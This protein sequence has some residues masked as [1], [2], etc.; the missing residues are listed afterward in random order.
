MEQSFQILQKQ[1]QILSQKQ[2]QSLSILSM[3]NVELDMFLQ[4]EYLEN[5]L[6]EHAESSL[7]SPAQ[8][9]GVREFEKDD[10]WKQRP[11]AELADL[12]TF[13]RE[14]IRFHKYDKESLQIMD[15][16][17]A[18]VEDSGYFTVPLTEVAWKC[19]APLEKVR[20]CLE[21]LQ[22]LE[23]V[24]VFS[25]NLQECLLKQLEALGI[26]NEELTAIIQ[27]HLED[28]ANGNIG[29]I[30]RSLHITTAQVR[31]YILMIETLNPRPAVG[32]SQ[33]KTEYIVP[34]IIMHKDQKWEIELNDH[35]MGHYEI[36]GYYLKL[37]EQTQDP[38]LKE[39]F[40]NKAKRV[41]MILQN[42]E[43]RRQTLLDLMQVI[44]T[45]QKAYFEGKGRLKPMTMTDLAAHMGIHPSTVS[46][47]VKGK[48]LQY[49]RETILLKSLFSQEVSKNPENAGTNAL[50]IKELLQHLIK[51][52]NKKKPYSD[53]ALKDKLEEKGIRISRRAIAKYREALGIKGSFERKE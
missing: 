32:F 43:Q 30:S 26:E 44:L 13:L 4:T 51:E 37:M 10:Q 9:G 21:E 34:D 19:Q 45:W 22:L 39:Y 52:E 14:Q 20:A 46:R 17:I 7:E 48:Y 18:C 8:E 38:Q 3:D 35:W 40:M 6:L 50:E 33:S 25:A 42:V 16:L 11:Q 31:K 15:Y 24:G 29:H 47:A 49:P 41:R 2:L 27:E 36:S 12:K 53:Q 23:P 28:V 5:P 1:K